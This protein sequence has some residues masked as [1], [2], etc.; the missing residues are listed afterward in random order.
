MT[1][2]HR[3]KA[4]KVVLPT[5]S[6]RIQPLSIYSTAAARPPPFPVWSHRPPMLALLPALLELL[7]YNPRTTC[8]LSNIAGNRAHTG[9]KQ[10]ARANVQK[11][12]LRRISIEASGTKDFPIRSNASIQSQ[13]GRSTVMANGCMAKMVDGRAQA[14]QTVTLFAGTETILCLRCPKSFS[15]SENLTM[16][17]LAF[18]CNSISDRKTVCIKSL[19]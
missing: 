18:P 9:S 19:P 2:R 1:D 11:A 16:C 5:Q 7:K 13:W 17:V 10:R 12:A 6:L 4:K 15:P 3:L 14:T 8:V